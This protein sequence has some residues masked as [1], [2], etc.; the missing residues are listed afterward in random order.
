[1]WSHAIEM[2]GPNIPFLVR[3][4]SRGIATRI[5]DILTKPNFKT[6][7]A[8][9]EDQL[10]TSPGNGKFIAGANLTGADIMMEYPL[11]A[12]QG[13]TGLNKD[14]YP[15]IFEYIDMLH[16]RPAYKRAIA[17]VEEATG[18]PFTMKL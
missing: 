6:H 11:F 16:E 3:P 7:F 15:K 5:E 2:K 13:R 12:G 8:F 18:K 17:K 10:K 14:E 1:M 9:L 4:F